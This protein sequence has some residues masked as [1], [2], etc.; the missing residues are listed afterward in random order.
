MARDSLIVVLEL[1]RWSR[2]DPCHRC[3][4][5]EH[6]TL[7]QHQDLID[8]QHAFARATLEQIRELSSAS[9]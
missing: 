3:R 9:H 1:E 5:Q 8:R 6:H 7:R 2:A 4:L